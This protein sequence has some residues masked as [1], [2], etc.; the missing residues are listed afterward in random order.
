MRRPVDSI[1]EEIK[2]KKKIT[3]KVKMEI[4][5]KITVPVDLLG[6]S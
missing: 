6:V 1:I 2:V 3:A 4:K 5:K